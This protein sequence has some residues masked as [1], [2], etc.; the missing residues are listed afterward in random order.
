MLFFIEDYLA[1]TMY[2]QNV[3]ILS[4]RGEFYVEAKLFPRNCPAILLSL[5]GLGW[6]QKVG[7]GAGRDVLQGDAGHDT[8]S[9]GE[10]A[11][12]LLGGVGN[13]RLGGGGGRDSLLGESGRDTLFG[14]GE[15]DTLIG[16][17]GD[18]RLTG[19][20]GRDIL[21]GGAGLDSL[22]GGANADRLAGGKGNDALWGGLGNDVLA[23]DQ[24]A[25]LLAGGAGDD[26]LGGWSGN[27]RLRGGDGNDRLY[28][29]RGN[30]VL[31]GGAGLDTL[32][33]GVGID[34]VDYS[35][36]A[37]GVVVTL[38]GVR[39]ATTKALPRSLAETIGLGLRG[40]AEADACVGIENI[41]GSNRT[42]ILVGSA[43]RNIIRG[44]GGDDILIGAAG[45]DVFVFGARHGHDVIGDFATAV[46]DPKQQDT[47]RLVGTRLRTFDDV[48]KCAAQTE[49][50]VVIE[51]DGAESVTLVGARLA[52]L[53]ASHF[54]FL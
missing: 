34:T 20:G 27:D 13:D 16:G 48:R 49:A 25:D 11:D 30:D 45:R 44:G 18:D 26:V 17:S 29:G 21:L 28:G 42:D 2:S 37:D 54:E 19:G 32:I 38:G 24:G 41:I 8:M 53:K 36:S 14:G 46:D 5:Y 47:I 15:N 31:N 40:D 52:S 7:L 22:R 10:G 9:G 50:G 3:P 12:F 6:T 4:K 23:G 1:T 39:T 33:G 43:V 35:D 51:V